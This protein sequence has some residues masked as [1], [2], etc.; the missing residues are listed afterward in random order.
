VFR[1]PRRA[2]R[3]ECM[4]SF[5][6]ESYLAQAPTALVDAQRR[7]RRVAE[8][9]EGIAYLRTT[10]VP[11]DETCFH[12]FGAP[13]MQALDE[14]VQLGAL[15]QVRIVEAVETTTTEEEP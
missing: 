11:G 4:P 15:G 8:L 10:F 9:G 1:L 5:L 12:L 2:G 13:S 6:V 14:A 7:A 3:L